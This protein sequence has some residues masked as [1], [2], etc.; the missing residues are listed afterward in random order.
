MAVTSSTTTK[1][2][3]IRLR[4]LVGFLGEK[5]QFGW[6][7]STFLGVTSTSFLLP[8]FPRTSLLAQYHGVIE[9]ARQVHDQH[10][11]IGQVFHLFRLP[12]E[13]EQDLHAS[14]LT[15]FSIKDGLT[16]SDQA[17]KQLQSLSEK[18]IQISPNGPIAVGDIED[19]TGSLLIKT[20][21]A[22][23]WGAFNCSNRTYPYLVTK[24]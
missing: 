16:D 12:S 5:N 11:G 1:N 7:Q 15:G 19:C 14:L 6:W 10:I 20:L 22:T 24:S 21:A 9:S 8:S 17:L 2:D 13:V 23:Y 3:L 18:L 4:L